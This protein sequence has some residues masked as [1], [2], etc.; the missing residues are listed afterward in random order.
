MVNKVALKWSESD[1]ATTNVKAIAQ[2]ELSTELQRLQKE[3]TLM[4]T[5]KNNYEKL[6]RS[7]ST[8]LSKFEGQVQ[9]R[10]SNAKEYLVENY[11]GSTPEVTKS[12]ENLDEINDSAS[13]AKNRIQNLKNI[14]VANQAH[15]NELIIKCEEEM[16]EVIAQYDRCSS[17][18][19]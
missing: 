7:L 6:I 13:S 5:A 12:R 14:A 17:I 1:I 4:Y 8:A 10:I 2:T 9:F 19:L 3:K 11:Y 16:D 15:I 18:K